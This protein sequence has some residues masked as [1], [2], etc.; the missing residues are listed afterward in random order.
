MVPVLF[1][2]VWE[3]TVNHLFLYGFLAMLSP[4]SGPKL[5]VLS[6]SSELQGLTAPAVDFASQSL[7][8]VR[9][10]E[11]QDVFQDGDRTLVLVNSKPGS[12]GFH[13]LPKDKAARVTLLEPLAAEVEEGESDR[14]AYPSTGP[15]SGVSKEMFVVIRDQQQLVD[16][17][18]AHFHSGN[19]CPSPP[20]VDFRDK[21]LVAYF[22]GDIPSGGVYIELRPY[23]DRSGVAHVFA[24][25][26]ASTLGTYPEIHSQPYAIVE[27][28]ARLKDVRLHVLPTALP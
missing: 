6:K 19:G 3:R 27:L 9:G 25:K 16:M 14:P 5:S 26:M 10:G 13:V 2:G 7:L 4:D 22:A 8:S 12:N 20:H 11:I 17:W 24:R 28:P 23:V 18:E 1:W 21:A 15:F